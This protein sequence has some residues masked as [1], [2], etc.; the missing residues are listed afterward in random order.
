MERLKKEG[1]YDNTVIIFASDHGSHFKTR[2]TDGH[3]NGYDDYKRSCHDGALH[4]PL[5]IAGGPFKGGVAV[6]ELVSTES[7][8]KT[9]LALAGVD[10]GD[11]MIGENLLDV[12]EKKDDN[13]PNQVFAQISESRVG[14]CVRT[15]NYLYS[16]YAP[17]VNGGE[18]AASDLYAD[19]FLYDLKVD[20]WQL[21]NV[22]ANPSYAQVKEDMRARLAD[23]IER[24]EG[25]RPAI[26]D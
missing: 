21:N 16:V 4:V 18:A 24:A 6:E 13:R 17:G 7:L 26:V 9:I 5:V 3:L 15:A 20:P 10:V 2:N 22:V 14:R 23:W 11:E 1:L 8:P 25:T 12:V 19:D